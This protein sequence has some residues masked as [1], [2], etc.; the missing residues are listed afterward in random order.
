GSPQRIIRLHTTLS[1]T[2]ASFTPTTCMSSL[3][4][5][6]EPPP[7]PSSFPPTWW[8]H[9]QHSSTN[10]IHV[11]PLHMSKPSQSHLPH[12]VTKKSYMRCPSN[13]IISNLVH[14]RHS[15]RKP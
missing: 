7:W 4:H 15:Q 12:L 3:N 13:K 14:P 8:L 6:H 5:I 1:S 9:P 10:I 11:P 2:S